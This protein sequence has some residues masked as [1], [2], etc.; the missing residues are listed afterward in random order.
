MTQRRSIE[1]PGIEHKA[2]I[3]MGCRIGN[4]VYSSGIS[5]HDPDTQ[6]TPS[7]PAEQAKVVF[8]N[9]RRFMQAAG[10]T[11]DDIIRVTFHVNDRKMREY[12]DPEWLAMFPDE[13]SR[14]ARH[15]VKAELSARTFFQIE[16]VA[17]LRG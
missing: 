7:D 13:H 12:L 10:G 9:V 8:Q 1:V 2:P 4:I 5:G 14:P 17:V 16:V 3:P 11:P 6:T 15:A